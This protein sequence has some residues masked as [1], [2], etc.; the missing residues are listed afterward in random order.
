M[1]TVYYY[2]YNP[3][4]LF[5]TRKTNLNTAIHLFFSHFIEEKRVI[6]VAKIM[7]VFLII[8]LVKLVSQNVINKMEKKRGRRRSTDDTRLLLR[9]IIDGMTRNRVR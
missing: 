2:Y 3:Y 9:I 5:A 8:A 4:N 1:S 6:I 7:T